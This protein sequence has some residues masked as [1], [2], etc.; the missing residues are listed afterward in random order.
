MPKLDLS[1]CLHHPRN[2]LPTIAGRPPAAC[3]SLMARGH[4]PGRGG[5]EG[6]RSRTSTVRV[7]PATPFFAPHHDFAA[8]SPRIFRSAAQNWLDD[9]VPSRA[10]W[11]QSLT[12]LPRG[13]A[14]LHS[15]DGLGRAG[16]G[17]GSPSAATPTQCRRK[18][19]VSKRHAHGLVSRKIPILLRSGIH[20]GTQEL[21]T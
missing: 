4:E 11:R 6:R 9:R 15:L 7:H 3:Q 10:R 8:I 18:C 21:V 1:S 13:R 5:A 2:G 14:R 16:Y 19:K 17:A 12:H 20:P